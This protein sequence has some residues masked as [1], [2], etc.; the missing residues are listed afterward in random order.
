M[1]LFRPKMD[2]NG[3]FWSIWVSRMLKC[4][5]ERGR[6]DQIGRSDHFGP[7]WSSTLSDST[8]ATPYSLSARNSTTRQVM[9]SSCLSTAVPLTH[10]NDGMKCGENPATPPLRQHENLLG[11]RRADT[12]AQ[13]K[14]GFS[15][16]ICQPRSWRLSVA[17]SR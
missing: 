1:D 2:Q 5:S 4:G 11:K 8:G 7:F 12:R 10:R 15:F 16:S 3:P 17:Q 14:V 13:H 9:D 6:F